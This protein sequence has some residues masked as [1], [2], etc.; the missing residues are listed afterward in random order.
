MV[1]E[2]TGERRCLFCGCVLSRRHGSL[3]CSPCRGAR[4]DCHPAHDRE[5]RR[6]LL[7]LLRDNPRHRLNVYRELGI[8]HCGAEA[9][10]CVKG[11]VRYLRRHGHVIL[12]HHD[13]TYE[14][15]GQRKPRGSGSRGRLRDRAC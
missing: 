14:Y 7:E 5:L 1:E 13:G 9:W 2:Q 3:V 15:R 8:E 12:G 10:V 4:R 11:H 6:R